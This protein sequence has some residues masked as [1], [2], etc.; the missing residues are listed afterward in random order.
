MMTKKEPLVTYDASFVTRGELS[1]AAA[2]ETTHAL[3]A[4]SGIVNRAAPR[5]FYFWGGTAQGG[6]SS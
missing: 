6:V 3:A 4:I 5:F 2:Y 1:P